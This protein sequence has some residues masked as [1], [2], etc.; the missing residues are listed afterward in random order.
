MI[1]TGEN[2]KH[3]NLCYCRFVHRRSHLDCPGV[4]SGLPR[5]EAG[6]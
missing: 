6:D 4:E 3:K 1:L 2:Q 5:W